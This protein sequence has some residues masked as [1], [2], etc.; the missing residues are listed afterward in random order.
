MKVYLAS[1][2]GFAESTLGYM[3]DI[4]RLLEQSGVVLHNPWRNP[5]GKRFEHI[6]QL[7]E[8]DR[9]LEE[10]HALNIEIGRSNEDM[11]RSCELMIGVLDGVDVDSGTASEIGF[12]YALGTRIIGIRTDF[13]QS[14][15]NDAARVNL[16]VQYWIE[17]S[18]G[19]IVSSLVQLKELLARS[20]RE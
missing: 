12:A 7:T 19:K 20:P 1:A 16:Q 14:G 4:E 3:N 9:R 2:L 10:L 13:R 6:E 5:L 11:I 8:H 17:A 18:G 15:D